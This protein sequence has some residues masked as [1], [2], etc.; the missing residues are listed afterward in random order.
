M[1]QIEVGNSQYIRDLNLSGIFKL[2]HKLGPI[3]RKELAENTGYSAA[4]ISNHVKTL[5]DRGFVIEKEKGH[6]TGGRKPVY[7]TV[8]PERGYIV[9]ID[10][11]V[12]SVSIVIFNLTLNI[13][14]KREFLLKKEISP[15]EAMDK[16]YVELEKM[17]ERKNLEVDNILGAGIAVPGL[18]NKEKGLLEF[19][20]NLGWQ[21][22]PIVDKF[23]ERYKI[24]IILENE[25]KAAAIGERE[26]VY[27]EA[28]NMVFVS[29][30]EGIGCG[31]IINGELYRG[32]SG[33]AGE[34]GHIIID[35]D[36]S[37]CHCGNK[38]CW[39]TVASENYI[40]EKGRQ[41]KGNKK[42][43][44]HQIYQLGHNGDQ[45]ILKL[46]STT[47]AYIGT[48]L[49]NIINSLG[50][51]LVII[52]GGITDIKDII[53]DEIMK[54]TAERSVSVCYQTADIKFSRLGAKAVAYGLAGYVFDNNLELLRKN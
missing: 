29:I 50:P 22:I 47:A 8:N 7:V 19:A 21:Q 48:G 3:S 49:A 34:F 2:I 10:I 20:P 23:Y 51:K 16:I 4:T 11:E 15:D 45:E 17:I 28:D 42:L 36:G 37:I 6:S 43:N 30:N 9:S 1:Q 46:F 53:K 54:V 12:D 26:F 13:E 18:I 39:E 35:N 31:I 33:N 24:P 44:K 25:A 32:A 41:L 38:G 5:I 40:M 27:P 52:G 14:L